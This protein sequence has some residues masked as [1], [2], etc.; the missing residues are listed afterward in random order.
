MSNTETMT[1]AEAL[2]WLAGL[3]KDC[4]NC[5]PFPDV[6]IPPIP[7]CKKCYGTGKVPV[8]DLREPC[9]CPP[10]CKASM[11]DYPDDQDWRRCSACDN[12]KGHGV[13]CL[14]CQGRNWVPLQGQDALYAA[15]EKDGWDYIIRSVQRTRSVHFFKVVAGDWVQGKDSDDGLAAVEAIQQEGR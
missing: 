12:T 5:N 13:W 1:S 15:M 2:L 4:P 8:L 11:W 10:Y 14:N 7:H 3:E 9:P 6:T